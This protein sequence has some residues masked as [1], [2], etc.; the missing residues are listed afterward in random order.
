VCYLPHSFLPGKFQL[1]EERVPYE[2]KHHRFHF[3]LILIFL[4]LQNRWN[5]WRF[6][7]LFLINKPYCKRYAKRQHVDFMRL[8]KI[9]DASFCV[10]THTMCP[11]GHM[12]S[13][14]RQPLDHERQT[15]QI[16]TM[17][18]QSEM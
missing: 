12:E 17:G 3:S 2:K 14:I 18:V 6:V 9:S 7:Y 5:P 8:A 13:F 15:G 16:R 11:A 10:L 4:S 1:T